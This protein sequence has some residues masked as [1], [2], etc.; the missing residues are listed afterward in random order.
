MNVKTEEEI[1]EK[2]RH[3]SEYLDEVLYLRKAGGIDVKRY[4]GEIKALKWVLE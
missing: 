1:V 4:E 3:I 2:I